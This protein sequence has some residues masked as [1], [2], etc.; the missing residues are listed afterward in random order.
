[1]ASPVQHDLGQRGDWFFIRIE[2][3]VRNRKFGNELGRNVAAISA[4]D[5]FLHKEGRET[6]DLH[7]RTTVA[8]TERGLLDYGRDYDP[9]P[10]STVRIDI[11]RSATWIVD[12]VLVF[13]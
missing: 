8:V 1:M 5:L 12:I 4:G 7:L 10:I 13:L 3:A 11:V 9:P 2:S 6:D